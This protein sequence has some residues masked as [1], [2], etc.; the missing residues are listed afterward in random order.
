MSNQEIREKIDEL[1]DCLNSSLDNVR[2]QEIVQE[3][4]RLSHLLK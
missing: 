1:H 2:Y 3:I 4:L